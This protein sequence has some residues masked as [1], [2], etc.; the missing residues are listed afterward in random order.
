MKSILALVAAVLTLAISGCAHKDA[1]PACKD[2]KS[3]CKH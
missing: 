3:C 1:K 2:G